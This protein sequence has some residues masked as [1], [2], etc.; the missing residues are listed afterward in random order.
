MLDW[1]LIEITCLGTDITILV[2]LVNS[3]AFE[4]SLDVS[5]VDWVGQDLF[6]L[7]VNR[8]NLDFIIHDGHQLVVGFI[9]ELDLVHWVSEGVTVKGFAW[10]D[11]P[12]DYCV[13]IIDSSYWSQV[14]L[15]ERKGQ[16]LNQNL[17]QFQSMQERHLV[18]IPNDDISLES[19]VSF[20]ARGNV[21]STFTYCDSRDLI[22]MSSEEI[23]SPADNVSD[24]NCWTQRVDE[25]FVHGVQYHSI[26]YLA[27]EADDCLYL[28]LL[29]HNWLSIN[30]QINLFIG[31]SINILDSK[32][33]PLFY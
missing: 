6:V 13:F 30:I 4:H 24:D 10:T 12:D 21:V 28:Q 11:V 2:V 29:F 5:E 8:N 14:E 31:L 32:C 18:E 20:L 19:H 17:V 23:L 25:V 16:I 27:C 7:F 1:N 15:I 22:V 26:N 33:L 3:N 9:E